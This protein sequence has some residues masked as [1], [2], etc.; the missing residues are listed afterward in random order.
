MTESNGLPCMNCKTV[1]A[2]D[3][4]M[5]FAQ[6]FVCPTCHTQATHF[7]HRLEGELK[8][9]LTL[10]QEAIRIALVKG[11]FHFPEGPRG[12]VSKREVLEEALRLEAA[13]EEEQTR[14]ASAS[15]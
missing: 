2:S 14:K 13:R 12:E 7:F 6:V 8:S 10:S 3:A 5:F 9:L 4:G 15:S 1:I 11:Q